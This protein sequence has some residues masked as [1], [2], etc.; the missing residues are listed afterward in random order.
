MKTYQ[1]QKQTFWW[2]P[3]PFFDVSNQSYSL[4]S[5]Q[6]IHL[7]IILLN[8]ISLHVMNKYV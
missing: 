4:N 8:T 7:W 1:E 2:E 3:L 5:C 6:Q